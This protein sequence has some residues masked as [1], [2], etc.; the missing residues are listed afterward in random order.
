LF[1]HLILLA[2]FIAG[3]AA[4]MRA[5]TDAPRPAVRD[6]TIEARF[7]LRLEAPD[8]REQ[9]ASG[10]LTWQ[11]QV[12]GD[13]LLLADPLGQGVAELESDPAGAR[14]RLASGR[15]SRAAD[16][17]SLLRD[18]L[19]YSLPVA[20]LPAWLLGR[21]SPAGTLRRDAQGRPLALDEDGWR[22]AYAYDDDRA[23]ALPARLTVLRQGELELR[24]RI[25]EWRFTP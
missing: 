6:F 14:L 24:L 12:T 1:R 13:R 3:C 16:A 8:Q 10:R 22:I 25:E 17:D 2:A 4:P 20:R 15:E 9:S 18:A 23:D 19:G 11:H 7:S 21:A 5:P